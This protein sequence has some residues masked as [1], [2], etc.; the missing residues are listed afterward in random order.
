[1]ITIYTLSKLY[2]RDRPTDNNA[3]MRLAYRGKYCTISYG[4]RP[5]TGRQVSRSY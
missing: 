4:L 2:D 1:M 3:Y 5:F